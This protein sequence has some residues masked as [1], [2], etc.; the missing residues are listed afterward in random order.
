MVESYRDLVV[1]R[2]AMDAV[3]SIY[4]LA[5]CLPDDEK[6]GLRSQMARAAISV[7]ANIAEGSCCGSRKDYA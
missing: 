3:V 4:D 1:C 7:P 6:Y 5:A 2:K